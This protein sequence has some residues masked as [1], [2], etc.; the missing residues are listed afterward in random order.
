MQET[1]EV[2]NDEAGILSRIKV[3]G[4]YIYK[5]A[6]GGIPSI[7]FAPDIEAKIVP[8][9]EPSLEAQTIH[10]LHIPQTLYSEV[11]KTAFALG[12]DRNTAM[13]DLLTKGLES[14]K[15]GFHPTL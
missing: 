7:A 3:P 4:G 15:F 5:L 6:I 2:V 1:W 11:G 8:L 14:I 10:T 12:V 9:E 13:V